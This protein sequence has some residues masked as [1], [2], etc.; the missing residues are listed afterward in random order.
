MI[1]VGVLSP[2][3]TTFPESGGAV[4]R[5]AGVQAMGM[6]SRVVAMM[7]VLI[8]ISQSS[9]LYFRN[10]GIIPFGTAI[11]VLYGQGDIPGGRGPKRKFLPLSGIV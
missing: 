5:I 11:D 1:C 4:T 9:N 10:A 2:I 7:R 8:F 3:T 6:S